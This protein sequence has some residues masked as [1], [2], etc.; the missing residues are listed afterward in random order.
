MGS[1]QA[2]VGSEGV[3]AW[4]KGF[5]LPGSL[6]GPK[7][8]SPRFYGLWQGCF[9]AL[10]RWMPPAGT[11]RTEQLLAL[12]GLL[13]CSEQL[14]CSRSIAAPKCFWWRSLNSI[15]KQQ[16]QQNPFCA[17]AGL[18]WF[19]PLFSLHF[20]FPQSA[21]PASQGRSQRANSRAAAGFSFSQHSSSIWSCPGCFQLAEDGGQCQG[22]PGCWH[23]SSLPAHRLAKG[24]WDWHRHVRKGSSFLSS[25]HCKAVPTYVPVL[26]SRSTTCCPLAAWASSLPLLGHGLAAFISRLA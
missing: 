1:S 16:Q 4:P 8:P 5:S 9:I 13:H 7:Q 6:D 17:A 20:F 11:P 22:D 21:L 14:R 10:Q 24:T 2:G 12:R 3:K 19:F 15:F 18:G 23:S 26:T 25:V